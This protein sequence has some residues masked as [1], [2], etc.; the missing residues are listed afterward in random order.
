MALEMGKRV[1]FNPDDASYMRVSG[2]LTAEDDATLERMHRRA[3]W[4]FY[5]SPRRLYR[6]VA[7]MPHPSDFVKVGLKHF[8]LKFL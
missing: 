8:R 5:G 2:N 3:H 1:E 4:K 6:I 7:A